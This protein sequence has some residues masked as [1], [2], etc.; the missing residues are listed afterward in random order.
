MIYV[1]DN[2]PLSV[3]FKNY[4]RGVFK[5]LWEGFDELVE[6]GS[7]ISTREVLREIEESSIVPLR[8]WA[9]LNSSIFATPTV[10]EALFVAEIYQVQ[11]FQQNIEQKKILKGGN[12]ADP[13]VIARAVVAGATVV[14]MEQ[15]KQGAAKIPNICE[16]F[17]VP[18]IS[19]EEFMQAEG[20]TF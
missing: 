4:Y 9:K 5:T 12:N 18:C 11:H 3:L 19:L 20:W 2:S 17:K 16:H 8:N 6:D 13:F 10:E 7:I 1:F 14:T 15:R